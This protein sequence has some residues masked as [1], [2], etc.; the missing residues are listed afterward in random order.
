MYE[1]TLA[2]IGLTINE[3]KVYE[4]L[5]RM[6]QAPI[7]KIA[8]RSGVHRRNIYD[9]IAKLLDKGLISELVVSGK[10]HYIPRDPNRLADILVERQNE[11][12]AILP[13][14]QKEYRKVRENEEAYFYRGMEGFKNY[15]NDILEQEETVYFIGAKAFWLD[16]RLQYFLPKFDSERKK[17]GIK[18]M[19]LFDHE[20]K[21]NKPEILK[22]VGKPYKFLPKKYSSPTA[23]DIFGDYVVSFTGVEVGKLGDNPIQFVVKSR[24]LADGYRKF[25]WFMWDML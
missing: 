25:F 12:G 13:S 1:D 10:K 9:S 16:P 22:F 8:V 19:H 15:L 24:Q 3:V 18:F 6:G 4:A 21:E 5:I 2:K 20:V 11:L 17:R 7:E 23:I 14:L